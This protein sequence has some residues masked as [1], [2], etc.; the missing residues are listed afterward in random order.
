MANVRPS[1]ETE[2]RARTQFEQEGRDMLKH[3]GVS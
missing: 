1:Q 2:L 3:E